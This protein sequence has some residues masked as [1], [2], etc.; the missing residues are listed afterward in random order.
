MCVDCRAINNITILHPFIGKF[1]A[2]YF[3]DILIYNKSLDEHIKHLRVVFCA[4][5]EARLF[6][7]LKKCT[8]YTDRVAFLSYVVTP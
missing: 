2:V 5:H 6:A 7:N 4:L 3:N 8:F 1:V